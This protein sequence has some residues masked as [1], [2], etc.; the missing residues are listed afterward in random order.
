MD[1]KDTHQV[2][3]SSSFAISAAFD[4]KATGRTLLLSNLARRL[5]PH[6]LLRNQTCYFH[7]FTLAELPITYKT[8]DSERACLWSAFF[9]LLFHSMY[10]ERV[11]HII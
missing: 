3:S 4:A 9:F 5:V 7:N 11:D 1:V 8:A 2:D 10:V 6:H